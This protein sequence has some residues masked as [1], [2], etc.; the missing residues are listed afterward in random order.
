MP[1]AS[2]MASMRGEEAGGEDLEATLPLHLKRLARHGSISSSSLAPQ[3]ERALMPLEFEVGAIG[4]EEATAMAASL[5]TDIVSSTTMGE[6]REL[7][8]V[9]VSSSLEPSLRRR[10]NPATGG[11]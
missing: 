5:T 6:S 4:F 11:G 2:S 8:V 7:A 9:I 1:T 10:A 3:L